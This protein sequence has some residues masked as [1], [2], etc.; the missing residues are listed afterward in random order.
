MHLCHYAF[1][2]VV[3]QQTYAYVLMLLCRPSSEPTPTGCCLTD[4]QHSTSSVLPDKHA[5]PASLLL[6]RLPCLHPG[7]LLA[8]LCHVM[9]F[10]AYTFR[11]CCDYFVHILKN[12]H[13]IYGVSLVDCSSIHTCAS[14]CMDFT[15]L[16]LHQPRIRVL[17]ARSQ[18]RLTVLTQSGCVASGCCPRK[19]RQA[20]WDHQ[21]MWDYCRNSWQYLDWQSGC[22]TARICCCVWHDWLRLCKLLLCLACL[23]TRTP[24]QTGTAVYL[25][26]VIDGSLR[27]SKIMAKDII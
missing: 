7:A 17:R 14:C 27:L 21:H 16:I 9:L 24:C 3:F 13:L 22:N 6:C 23:C 18:T 20:T 12:L 8:L 15:V 4:L 19:C 10:C 1:N 25:I 11:W 26:G 5:V 2:S